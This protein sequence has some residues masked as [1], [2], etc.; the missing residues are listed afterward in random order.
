MNLFQNVLLPT[1][2]S[3]LAARAAGYA[4]SLVEHHA[5]TL[6]IVHVASDLAAL[7]A[8]PEAGHVI[9]TTDAHAHVSSSEKTLE[10]FI[11]DHLPGSTFPIHTSVLQ[12]PPADK[13]TEYAQQQGIDA[14]VIGT[15]AAGMLAR[16]VL[17]SVSKA[18]LENASCPVLMVPTAPED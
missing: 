16:I 2:F 4:R 10:Q 1:D 9:P 3:P 8:V 11:A 6:H 15:H 13:I 14:I 17:G 12:G 5:G 7:P 18:V